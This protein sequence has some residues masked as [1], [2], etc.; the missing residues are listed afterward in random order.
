MHINK[1][2]GRIKKAH[3][4]VA[5]EQADRKDSKRKLRGANMIMNVPSNIGT[6]EMLNRVVDC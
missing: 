1:W 4:L 5:S 6:N 3:I 2:Q